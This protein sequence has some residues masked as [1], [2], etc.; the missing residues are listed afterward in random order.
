M[1]EIP[2]TDRMTIAVVLLAQRGLRPDHFSLSV[3]DFH[4]LPEL[5][6]FGAQGLSYNHDRHTARFADYNVLEGALIDG[7]SVKFFKDGRMLERPI[8]TEEQAQNI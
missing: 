1:S 3:K 6:R 4:Q 5:A 8:D 7:S 2:V